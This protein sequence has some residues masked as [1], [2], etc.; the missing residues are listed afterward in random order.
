MPYIDKTK[1][2]PSWTVDQI[3]RYEERLGIIGESRPLSVQ[4]HKPLLLISDYIQAWEEAKK[5][6]KE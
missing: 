5:W 1:P 4:T 6:G 2:S 3:Y